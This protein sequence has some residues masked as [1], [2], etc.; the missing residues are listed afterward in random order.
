MTGNSESPGRK[1]RRLLARDGIIVAPLTFNPLTAKLVED[2]GFEVNYVG[3]YG[4]GG[5]SALGEP[6][7][8]ASEMVEATQ[9]IVKAT[10]LPVIADAG[11]GFG[12]LVHTR[13]TV[14]EFERAGT[15]GIHL[16]DQ[17]VPK[18]V[19]YHRGVVDIIP[20][21]EMVAKLKIALEAR[22]D[23]DF[24]I[25]ARTDARHARSGGAEEMRRRLI[26]YAEA[27]A[28]AVIGFP[29]DV[30]EA[31]A[32]V[33]WVDKPAV[34]AVAEGRTTRPELTPA[35]LQDL[36]YKMAIVSEGPLLAAYRAVR[37]FYQNLRASGQG[38]LAPAELV[39]CRRDLEAVIGLPAWFPIEDQEWELE[40]ARRDAASQTQRDVRRDSKIPEGRKGNA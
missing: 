24:V 36:G 23:S 20:L 39:E 35:E 37:G 21:R 12:S 29:A 38:P 10:T 4:I 22:E 15:A 16:E 33:T 8:T 5:E 27:G 9:R 11:A 13:R 7:L 31:E 1:L 2:L 6:L 19:G 18:R 25:I 28:D 30:G 26:A 3:G 14:R 32:L 40:G 34:Y 17:V